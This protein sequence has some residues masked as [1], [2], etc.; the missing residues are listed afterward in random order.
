MPTPAPIRPPAGDAPLIRLESVS[1]FYGDVLGVNRISLEIGAGI[2][3]LIGPNGAGKSTLLNLIA[4]LIRPTR[5]RITV[6]GHDPGDAEALFSQLGFC[7]QYDSFPAGA[8]GREWVRQ[9]LR[10]HGYRRADAEALAERALARVGMT[11]AAGRRLESYSKGMRQRIR[12][13]QILAY[14]PRLLILD[15]PLN[16]LDPLARSEMAALFRALAGE[17]RGLLISSH[18]LHELEA[19]SDRVILLRDGYLA[20][21]G[22]IAAVRED[23]REHDLQWLIRCPRPA[24]LAALG[25]EAR[26]GDGRP[27]CN[28][29]RI[30]DR[31]EPALL[32]ATAAPA[33]FFLA[34]NDWIARGEIEVETVTPADDNLD[35]VY[36]YLVE[37][38]PA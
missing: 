9:N 12:L 27:L 32:L 29:V 25:L 19:L 14:E 34:L 23:I 37:E 18:I 4:G 10:L 38:E 17:G 28:Q 7:T 6:L 20:G 36:R 8:R 2:T 11:E 24:R 5:G 15:E 3:S 31:P 26:A 35:A 13:A 33:A 22:G 21:E 1:R 30:F 16:G